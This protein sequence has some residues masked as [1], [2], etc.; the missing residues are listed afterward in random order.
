MGQSGA[1]GG[2]L[3]GSASEQA[4]RILLVSVREDAVSEL[5]SALSSKGIKGQ[6]DWVSQSVLVL[7]RAQDMAPDF[8]L[9]DDKLDGTSVIPLIKLLAARMPGVAVLMLVEQDGLASASQAVLAGARGFLVKPLD[10]DEVVSALQQLLEQRQELSSESGPARPADGR[11]VV[12]WAAKGGTGR[13]TL[14][15][16]TAISL[17]MATNEPVVLVDA[18]YAAPALDVALNLNAERNI[19]DL[20]PRLSRV[21]EELV[22][23]IVATHASGVQVLLAPPGG[24]SSPISSPQIQQILAQL[25]R[26]Y[27]WVVVDLGLPADETAFAF[28]DGADRIVLSV[29]PE[30]VGL[31]NTR[32]MLDYLR[33]QGYPEDKLWLVENRSTLKGGVTTSDIEGRLHLKIQFFI[34]DDQAL[35]THSVNLGVPVVMSYPRSPLARA[36]RAFAQRLAEDLST[37]TKGLAQPA[38]PSRG[39]LMSRLLHH[40]PAPS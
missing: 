16:N 23:G 32:L 9:I 7:G 36:F 40:T 20:V 13:T 12:C 33:E 18:D 29:L 24:L 27:S 14:A 34:P 5:D 1:R 2:Q 4:W 21:D 26:M 6:F 38:M 30:M 11:L 35:A 39:G 22:S 31:R 37:G 8:V 28:L 3:A 17:H 15:I 19:V 10:P 25:K